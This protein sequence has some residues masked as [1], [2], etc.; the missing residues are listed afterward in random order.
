MDYSTYYL[1]AK[2]LLTKIHEAANEKRYEEAE[3]LAVL[4]Q[5]AA[6]HL[7]TSLQQK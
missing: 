3:Q 2:K 5:I 7:K 6:L 1:E 4:L